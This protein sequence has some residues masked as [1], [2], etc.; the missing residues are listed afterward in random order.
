MMLMSF[1]GYN[2]SENHIDLQLYQQN[3]EYAKKYFKKI[4]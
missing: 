2:M 4:I 1:F 3:A